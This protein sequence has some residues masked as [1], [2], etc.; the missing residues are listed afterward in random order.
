MLRLSSGLGCKMSGWLTM[1][2]IIAIITKAG[3]GATCF[4]YNCCLLLPAAAT[5][6]RNEHYVVEQVEHRG[7]EGRNVG[8]GGGIQ[9]AARFAVF[10][11]VHQAVVGK[12]LHGACA[13]V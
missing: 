3:R 13:G 4:C 6:A 1:W 8:E 11:A 10:S 5:H 12:Q 7:R 2:L 9:H